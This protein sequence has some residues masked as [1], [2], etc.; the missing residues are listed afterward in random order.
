VSFFAKR[1]A[2]HLDKDVS[3]RYRAKKMPR[4]KQTGDALVQS[5]FLLFATDRGLKERVEDR[6]HAIRITG[7]TGGVCMGKG[8]RDERDVTAE[9]CGFL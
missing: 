3:W 8:T 2:I 1:S 7:G 9:R 4:G 5:S 6:V